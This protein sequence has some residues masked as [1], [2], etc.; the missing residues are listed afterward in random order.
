MRHLRNA[1]PLTFYPIE[2][3]SAS[4]LLYEVGEELALREPPKTFCQPGLGHIGL[5]HGSV[6]LMVRALITRR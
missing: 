4:F 5:R 6:R 3:R 2:K 1:I